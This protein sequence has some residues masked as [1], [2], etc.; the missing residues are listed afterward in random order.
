MA[1]GWSD[2]GGPACVRTGVVT[3]TSA[4]LQNELDPTQQRC[5]G[6]LIENTAQIEPGFSGGPLI[7]AAGRLIGLNVAVS[8]SRE[9]RRAYAI[10]LSQSVHQV[11]ARLA[12]QA[13][14]N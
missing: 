13:L 1:I 2:P 12:D 8:G 7:D 14:E 11:V 10:Q 3:D 6:R 5:Y 4:S 9:G